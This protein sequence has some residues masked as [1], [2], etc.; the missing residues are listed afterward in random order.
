MSSTT[1]L[2]VRQSVTVDVPP[3]R[4]FAVFTSDLASWWPLDSHH[5]GS[6]PAVAV[7]VEPRVGGRW[8]ERAADGSECDWG[9][10]LAWEP[11]HR[12]VLGVADLRRLAAR[13]GSAHRGRGPLRG[14]GGRSHEGRA[15]APRPRG[16]R[17]RAQQ[18]R[19]VFGSPDGWAGLLER[20]AGT[21]AER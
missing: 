8:Y 10:V 17:D 12:V 19:D 3:E 7:V 15:R 11:P 18:M 4:A 14:A 6:Q 2:A 13:S 20:F 5:I 21:A 1:D 9:R 16:L